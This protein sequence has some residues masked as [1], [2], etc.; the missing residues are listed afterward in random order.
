VLKGERRLDDG[1]ILCIPGGFSYGDHL[2]AG[3]LAGQFIKTKLHEQLESARQKPIIAICNGFQIAV[4]S[5]LFGD[6]VALTVNA[7]GTFRNIMRQSHL[8]E[9]DTNSVW[10]A[11]LGGQVLRFPCAHGEGRLVFDDTGDWK[12]ALEY[13]PDA[14]PDG[15]MENIGGITSADGLVF[16]LMD[17]PERYLDGPG[18][19]DI[20]A[21]GVKAAA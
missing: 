12:V 21:N 13:P 9:K 6:G 10:L 11:G 18:N 3:S 14:N 2:G 5:G 7:A 17:H 15:S 19:L 4:R 16:G 20:F 1:D 8:V